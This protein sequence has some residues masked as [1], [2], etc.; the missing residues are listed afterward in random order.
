[1]RVAVKYGEPLRWG[2]PSE[3]GVTMSTAVKQHVGIR[4]D[5]VDQQSENEWNS[6]LFFPL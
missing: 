4:T 2:D 3:R 5:P 1:M 6:D